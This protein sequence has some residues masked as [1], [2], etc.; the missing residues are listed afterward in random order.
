MQKL[1][2]ALQA[3]G[4]FFCIAPMIASYRSAIWGIEGAV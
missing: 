3:A 1:P 2:A 4:P